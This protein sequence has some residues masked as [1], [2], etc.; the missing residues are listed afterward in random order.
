MNAL[1]EAVAKTRLRP[2]T[3]TLYLR[4]V[5]SYVDFVGQS[6]VRWT[7]STVID[8]VNTLRSRLAVGTVNCM[9]AGVRSA[10]RR[11]AALGLIKNNFAAAVEDLPVVEEKKRR[12]VPLSVGRQILESCSGKSM[13]DRR[14]R[15]VLALG[16]YHG[17]RSESIVTIQ[18]DDVDFDHARLTVTIKG[19]HR[20]RLPLD[21]RAI[22]I[23]RLWMN[24]L[25]KEG[26]SAGAVFRSIS[27][28]GK[29]GEHS[30]TTMS[31]YNIV[32]GRAAQAGIANF[33]PHLMRHSFVSWAMANGATFEQIMLVTGHKTVEMLLWYAGD[34]REAGEE[35][36]KLVPDL[37]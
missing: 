10:S 5:R 9:L 32:R 25:R 1:E 18:F 23:L 4:S 8:W 36:K 37:D 29:L 31:L 2:K 35:A 20:H 16:F 28:H 11:A 33:H 7:G 22:P 27:R 34:A 26:L 3:T 6:E 12:P 14:D 13:R 21:P 30:M 17:L 24:D 19:G 15:A